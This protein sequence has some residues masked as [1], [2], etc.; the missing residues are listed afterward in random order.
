MKE[1]LEAGKIVSTVGLKGEVKVYPWTNETDFLCGFKNLYIDND[2]IRL[3]VMSSRVRKNVVIMRFD[4]IDSIDLAKSLC[5]KILYIN[6]KD[7]KLGE[8][9]Y[10]IQ[11]ILG[12]KVLDINT[13]KNYGTVTDVFQTGAN[14]VYEVTDGK[15]KKYLIPVINDVVLNVDMNNQEIKINP[16]EGIFEDE[17]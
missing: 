10:F 13:G 17:N 14:D 2:K 15:N 7:I 4:G 8:N 3:E 5:G 11:D 6:R 12:M 9:E 16:L 1:F